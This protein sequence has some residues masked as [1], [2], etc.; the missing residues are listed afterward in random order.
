[1]RL[2]PANGGSSVETELG[3]QWL[4]PSARRRPGRRPAPPP[5]GRRASWPLWRTWDPGVTT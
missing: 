1:M 5:V 2:R 4:H 3:P